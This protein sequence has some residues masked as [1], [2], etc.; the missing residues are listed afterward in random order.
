MILTCSLNSLK[1]KYKKGINIAI[2]KIL[3]LRP[4]FNTYAIR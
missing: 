2:G 4:F 3:I 1:Q